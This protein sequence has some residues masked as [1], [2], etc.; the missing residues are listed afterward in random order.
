ML[1]IQQTKELIGNNALTDEEAE[2]IR[3]SMRELVEIIFDQWKFE[4][5][6]RKENENEQRQEKTTA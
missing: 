2:K 5:N 6:K 3:N 4:R 1:T